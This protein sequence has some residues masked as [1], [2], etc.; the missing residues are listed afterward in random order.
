VAADEAAGA[1]DLGFEDGHLVPAGGDAH[2]GTDAGAGQAGA[3]RLG[4]A[5][6]VEYGGGAQ[7]PEIGRNGSPAG[8]PTTGRRAALS[9]APVL[10]VTPAGPGS[11]GSGTSG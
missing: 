9:A 2:R 1:F 11:G 5:S 7:Q 6:G 10:S 4:G 3:G 8:R